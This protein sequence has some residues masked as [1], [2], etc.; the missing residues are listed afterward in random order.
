M[1]VYLPMT[2]IGLTGACEAYLGLPRGYLT[3]AGHLRNPPPRADPENGHQIW[4]IDPP[5][6]RSSKSLPTRFFSLRSD[7]PIPC[8]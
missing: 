2:Q 3:T 1:V 7:S 6:V 8:T 4:A 5:D